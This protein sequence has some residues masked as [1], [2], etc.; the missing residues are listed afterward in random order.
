MSKSSIRIGWSTR[1]E[2]RP[3]GVGRH[4]GLFHMA[5]IGDDGGWNVSV[6]RLAFDRSDLD[7][8]RDKGLRLKV[9]VIGLLRLAD[10]VSP[11][12][13]QAVLDAR[14]FG[15]VVADPKTKAALSAAP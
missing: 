14:V 2:G 1:R 12:L 15:W 5:R 4:F 3:P 7:P 10:D 11:A 6:G 8:V 9:T 13:A